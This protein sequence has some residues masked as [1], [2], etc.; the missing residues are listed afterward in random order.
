MTPVATATRQAA[1]LTRRSVLSTIRSP[2]DWLP[3]FVF[4]L[5]IAA[6]YANQF[7]DATRLPAFPEVDSFL[8][9][10]L[11]AAILQGIAIGSANGG[12]DLALD[13]ENG[14]FDRLVSSP[15]AR[16]SI[17]VGRIGGSALFAAIQA[18]VLM[19]VFL[20]F[21]APIAGGLAGAVG[22]V[23]IAVFLSIAI[24]GFSLAVALRTG[25]QEATQAMFPLT[26]TLI[27]ISSA[28]FPTALMSGWYQT[29]AEI[30]PFTLII[31]PTRELVITG[32]SWSEFGSAIMF[33]L[34]VAAVSLSLAYR[35]Y[36]RRLRMA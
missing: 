14:F 35:M 31:D 36:L 7:D 15:V 8:Q 5:L 22:V 13:I 9:F 6:V 24:G 25:S 34:L 23:V 29:V 11:P 12:T 2:T 17:L 30:N 19:L 3:T 1:Y 10:V 33:T 16:L 26:F 32:W 20:A 27:F 18:T 28:F 21:G 4:P